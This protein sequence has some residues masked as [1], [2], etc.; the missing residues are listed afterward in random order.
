MVSGFALRTLGFVATL[1]ASALVASGT[2]SSATK[3][4]VPGSF[5]Y[6]GV[7]ENGRGAPTHYIATGDGVKLHFLDALSQGRPSEPYRVCIGRLGKAPAVCWNRT[8]KFGLDQLS[9]PA[10]LPAGVPLG[11]LTAQWL[12]GRRMVATWRFLYVRGG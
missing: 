7:V 11:I 10:T 9:L 1:A 3:I 5:R 6:A 4:D 2:A 12:V 8:A